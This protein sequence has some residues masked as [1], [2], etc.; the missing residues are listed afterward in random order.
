MKR[1]LIADDDAGMRAA[2]EARFQR[3]GWL[4]DV[5]GR[6]SPHSAVPG[7]RSSAGLRQESAAL[8]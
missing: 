2:L 8:L 7:K 6:A 3:R 4:V 5:A 1:L